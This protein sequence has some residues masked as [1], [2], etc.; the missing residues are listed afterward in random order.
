M[1][2][3]WSKYVDMRFCCVGVG[4][5]YKWLNKSLNQ[6]IIRDQ[7]CLGWS[8]MNLTWLIFNHYIRVCILKCVLEMYV[9]L[10]GNGEGVDMHRIFMKCHDCFST[11][12]C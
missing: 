3:V 9:V 7:L 12:M 10:L 1:G 6:I 2:G 8:W 5:F 11:N 4:C